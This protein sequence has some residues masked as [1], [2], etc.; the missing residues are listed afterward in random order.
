[1]QRE[2]RLIERRH[3]LSASE[4]A[5]FAAFGL[6]A[7]IGRVLRGNGFELLP[8][9]ELRLD[10]LRGREVRNQNVPRADLRRRVEPG[11]VLVEEVVDLRFA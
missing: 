1:M 4:A 11:V 5:E 3:H 2:R 9:F 10:L 6:A 7:R 8:G